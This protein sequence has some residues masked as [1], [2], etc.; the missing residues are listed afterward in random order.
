MAWKT[1]D[2]GSLFVNEAGNLV[3]IQDS[4]GETIYCADGKP[5]NFEEFISKAVKAHP[6]GETVILK[7]SNMTGACG[8][9]INSV[10]IANPWLKASFNITEQ[11]KIAAANPDRAKALMAVA[12]GNNRDP[13]D[14]IAKEQILM[15]VIWLGDL[16]I[17]PILFT[18]GIVSESL[19]VDSFVQSGVMAES[20]QHND[21]L[22]DPMGGPK[23]TARQ[24]CEFGEPAPNLSSD[25]PSVV[26]VPSKLSVSDYVA[27]RQSLNVSLYSKDF[28][29]DLYGSDPLA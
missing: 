2:D 25:D 5:A 27:A 20:E 10:G 6:Y 14:G 24:P 1:K 19:K 21:L 28:A 4:S 15:S 22:R 11:Q 29:A 8:T 13:F 18:M 7:G 23:L 9:P 26:S 12:I 16:P 17:V 3:F